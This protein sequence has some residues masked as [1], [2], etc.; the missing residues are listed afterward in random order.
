MRHLSSFRLPAASRP[1]LSALLVAGIVLAGSTAVYFNGDE[2]PV[3][4]NS[5]ELGTVAEMVDVPAGVTARASAT[6]TAAA[7][8]TL[9]ELRVKE[10]DT[11]RVGQV[12]AVIDSPAARHQLKQAKQALD[13]AKR[14][15]RGS[16]G[17]GGDL[18]RR[19]GATDRAAARA[20]TT[21]RDA[22]GKV[23]DQ[24]LRKALLAQ[25]EAARQQYQAAARA[26]EQAVRAVDRGVAGLNSALNALSAA[27]RI[28]AQQAYDLAKA[29]VDA[30]TLR[31]PIGGVVQLGGAGATPSAPAEGLAGLLRSAGALTGGAAQSLSAAPGPAVGI[32]SGVS[33]GGRVTAGTPV[34]TVVDMSE[35]GLVAELD[36]ADVLMVTVG[37]SG[38]AELDAVPGVTYPAQVRT[39]DVLPTSSARGGVSYRIRLSLGPGQHVEAGT[40]PTPRPGMSAVLRLRVREAAGAVTVPMAAVFSDDGR[41]LVWV[42]RDGRAERVP[43]TIG[44]Q[45]EDMVQII[46]GVQPGDQVVV[47]GA[48]R[49]RAGQQLP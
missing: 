33:V 39:V 47:R 32:D 45:G 2:V 13:A 11:V 48:D 26:A 35:L 24:K 14:V 40:A 9:A 43:V 3:A 30:L 44:V 18:T 28:Q 46:D 17:G 12:V 16:A 20:F 29:T 34:L 8:G 41:D 19:L 23:A 36:E 7:E 15:G 25:I 49:V 22:A 6:L 4:L 37:M 27:Q 10:G 1:R 31:A 5:A 42:A 21:A 38:T